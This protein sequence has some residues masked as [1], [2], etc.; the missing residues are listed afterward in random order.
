MDN[1]QK[2]RKKIYE[3]RKELYFW[4]RVHENEPADINDP[5]FKLEDQIE[6]LEKHLYER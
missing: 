3:L 5:E 1:Y 6:E 2:K 4:Q